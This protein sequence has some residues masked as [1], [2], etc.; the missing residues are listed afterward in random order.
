MKLIYEHDSEED[1]I[2]ILLTEKEIKD[3][4]KNTLVSKDFPT[5]IDKRRSTN[6][7]IRREHYAAS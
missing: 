5:G 4:L 7:L 3:I 2:E 6:I 1:F